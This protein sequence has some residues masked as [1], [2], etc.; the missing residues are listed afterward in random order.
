MA[1]DASWWVRRDFMETVWKYSHYKEDHLGNS[2]PTL[3]TGLM[4]GHRRFNKRTSLRV[5]L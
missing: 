2:L 3:M 1:R 4:H 5:A